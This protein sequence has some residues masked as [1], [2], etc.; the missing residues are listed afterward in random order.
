M[1]DAHLYARVEVY[2]KLLDNPGLDKTLII[3]GLA[4]QS[5]PSCLIENRA[6]IVCKGRGHW[7]G[8]FFLFI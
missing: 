5:A 6:D 7:R 3:T 4:I 2:C 1:Q 8:I